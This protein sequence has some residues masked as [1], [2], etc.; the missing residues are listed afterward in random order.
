MRRLTEFAVLAEADEV[1]A[2]WPD[3]VPALSDEEQS[4]RRALHRPADRAAFAAAHVLARVCAAELA[5]ASAQGLTLRQRCPQCQGPHGRPSIVQLP[6]VHVSLAHSGGWV[7]AIAAPVPCG[8]DVELVPARTGLPKLPIDRA[9]AE[10]ERRWLSRQA[11]H[12]LAFSRLWVRKEAL[13]KAGV[14]SLDDLPVLDVADPLGGDGLAPSVADFAVQEAELDAGD[15]DRVV[16]AFARK[17][18]P[19]ADRGKGHSH[20]QRPGIHRTRPTG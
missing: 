18:E 11:D 13:I 8:I 6:A 16:A 2:T 19:G 17:G 12:A 20:D 3:V 1:L 7:A 15:A 5:G 10:A 9:L 4:R 14:G